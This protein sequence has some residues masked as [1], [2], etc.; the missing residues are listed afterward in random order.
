MD[1]KQEEKENKIFGICLTVFILI[2]IG[3]VIY[4]V[5]SIWNGIDGNGFLKAMGIDTSNDTI[6]LKE[7]DENELN[8]WKDSAMNWLG[9]EKVEE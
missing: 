7:K 3:A 9:F 6:V 1:K 4:G 2:V 5:V 8:Q